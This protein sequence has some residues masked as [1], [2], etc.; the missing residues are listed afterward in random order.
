MVTLGIEIVPH[1]RY[2]QK[3]EEEQIHGSRGAV[4]NKNT[5]A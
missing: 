3:N 5:P 4:E 1:A 2:D